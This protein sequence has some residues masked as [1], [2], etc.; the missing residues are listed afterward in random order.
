MRV[1]CLSWFA[2]GGHEKY[3][4]GA[5]IPTGVWQVVLM[6]PAALWAGRAGSAAAGPSWCLDEGSQPVTSDVM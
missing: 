3:L 5:E 1:D 2:G 6:I 4:R